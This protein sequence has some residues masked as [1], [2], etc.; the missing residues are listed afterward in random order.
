MLIFSIP[1]SPDLIIQ[2]LVLDFN[3]TLGVDGKL[4]EGVAELL[5]T[6][7]ERLVVHVVTADTYGTVKEALSGVNCRLFCL[8][9]DQQDMAKLDYISGLNK[10]QVCAIGNG[11]NDELMVRQAGLGI[12][13]M[14][15]EG[16]WTGTIL[17]SKLVFSD[18]RDALEL[19]FHPQ[20]MAASLRR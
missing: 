3:G 18:I 7:S 15:R 4:Q 11:R 13:L 6:L 8:E 14:G 10:A 17:A 2:H 1:G 20:R 12:G 5:N 19:L 16:A 9:P